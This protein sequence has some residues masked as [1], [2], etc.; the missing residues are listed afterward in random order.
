[1]NGRRRRSRAVA[2]W[3][4]R[5]A[6]AGSVGAGSFI[7]TS[8]LRSDVD[9]DR[10]AVDPGGA[11]VTEV[12]AV[13]VAPIATGDDPAVV[14]TL[15]DLGDWP[16]DGATVQAD[17]VDVLSPI[18]ASLNIPSGSP[19]RGSD[20]GGGSSPA[21]PVLVDALGLPPYDL[22][23]P[24]AE[25]SS[26]PSAEPSSGAEDEPLR[27][28]TGP[29]VPVD[30]PGLD[31]ERL[32]DLIAE[33]ADPDDP[34]VGFADPC[35]DVD[36]PHCPNP[37]EPGTVIETLSLTTPP[38]FR[39]TVIPRP[40]GEC[41]AAV[42]SD[43]IRVE[44]TS[45]TPIASLTLHYGRVGY[46]THE[47]TITISTPPD[48]AQDWI[49]RFIAAESEPPPPVVHCTTLG[50]LSADT[51]YYFGVSATDV[52]DQVY[53]LRG[54]PPRFDG[55]TG[56]RPPTLVVPLS[57]N[58]LLV[59][60]AIR[61]DHFVRI[62]AYRRN[63]DAVDAP[64][65]P[66]ASTDDVVDGFDPAI[67]PSGGI[68]RSRRSLPDNVPSYTPQRREFA[69]AGY[70]Q[71]FDTRVMG[72]FRLE[73]GSE[74]R[75]CVQWSVRDGFFEQGIE[76]IEAY[77]VFTP[78]ALDVTFSLLDV[79][80]T[81]GALLPAGGLRVL[82]WPVG[83]GIMVPDPF[84]GRWTNRVDVHGREVIGD[85]I[86]T[87]RSQSTDLYRRGARVTL[88]TT[89]LDGERHESEV[90]VPIRSCDDPCAAP[91]SEWFR[92]DLPTG[93]PRREFF[94]GGLGDACDRPSDNSYGTTVIQVRYAN[95]QSTGRDRWAISDP[96][97][98]DYRPPSLPP[99]PRLDTSQ[100]PRSSEVPTATRNVTVP[101]FADRPVSVRVQLVDGFGAPS[102]VVDGQP[103]E[104]TSSAPAIGHQ[105]EFTGLCP[106]QRVIPIVELTDEDG[107]FSRWHTY[108]SRPSFDPAEVW[109]R[110]EVLTSLQELPG[111]RPKVILDVPT[112]WMRIT[113]F[114]LTMDAEY[115]ADWARFRVTPS[116]ERGCNSPGNPFEVDSSPFTIFAD[117][118]VTISMDIDLVLLEGGCTVPTTTTGEP[119]EQPPPIRLRRDVDLG[120]FLSG[121]PI[122]LSGSYPIAGLADPD[123]SVDVTVIVN[124]PRDP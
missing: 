22:S 74:Y 92:L 27:G 34:P 49:E 61:D 54:Q 72:T 12:E 18:V 58:E 59:S 17:P 38:P 51:E 53:A 11:I 109:L 7:V 28:E 47:N 25:P 8:T 63:A 46:G 70:D 114:D 4:F 91:P 90:V 121:E 119:I 77:D 85:T 112:D 110:G 42:G 116:T 45:T 76:I 16:A 113:R 83:R 62:V 35:A 21:Q 84:C 19:R 73:E 75:L 123:A 33:L 118:V 82:V 103:T 40:E 100:Q 106:G 32:P 13:Q 66:C 107:N 31:V 95:R 88:R 87:V 65:E 24:S 124:P 78:D 105:L 26:D 5:I 104:M 86:C 43:E 71:D 56:V 41:A 39:V 60:P 108:G 14:E 79:T 57:G 6:I 81:D 99:T 30:V 93:A 1:M 111:R 10:T 2:V 44:I 97:E 68:S 69:E 29:L 80:T 122:V 37:G 52:F 98:P 102:C 89:D 101:V 50:E 96:V 23:E 94:C 67:G 48:V 20:A 3:L 64:V 15:P 120:Q 55:P 9:D 117:Q 115:H 36:D